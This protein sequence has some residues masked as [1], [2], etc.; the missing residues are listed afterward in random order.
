MALTR[1]GR[2]GPLG[3]GGEGRGGG[4]GKGGAGRGGAAGTLARGNPSPPAVAHT[5]AN[6]RPPRA[7]PGPTTQNSD[8]PPPRDPPPKTIPAKGSG[9]RLIWESGRLTARGGPPAPQEKRAHRL[10][11][12]EARRL[13]RNIASLHADFRLKWG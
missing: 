6:R 2:G 9:Y 3:W 8:D 12:D 5:A 10:A 13:N 7:Q 11:A 1:G 4:E